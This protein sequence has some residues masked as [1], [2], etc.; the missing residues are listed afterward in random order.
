MIFII[1]VKIK[2]NAIPYHRKSLEYLFQT[3]GTVLRALCVHNLDVT[4]VGY[5]FIV[6][7]RLPLGVGNCGLFGPNFRDKRRALLKS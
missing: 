3:L 2:Q 4:V 7:V 5:V 6:F 1:L